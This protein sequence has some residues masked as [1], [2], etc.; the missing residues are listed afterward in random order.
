MVTSVN[1]LA[2]TTG[3]DP[4]PARKVTLGYRIEKDKFGIAK[5][6]QQKSTL[7]GPPRVQECPVQMEAELSGE[8]V[9]MDDVSGARRGAALAIEVTI[10][11]VHVLERLRMKGHQ[12][13]I[14]P[15]LWRPMIMSFQQ[16]YGLRDGKLDNSKLAEIDE[17][18]YRGPDA[19]PKSTA[20]VKAVAS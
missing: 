16:L 20:V 18:L 7:V 15:D 4:I 10:L 1:A 12:N 8:H 2:R 5:L 11:Q 17:E 19:K 9:M 14:D 13:R 3:S 6:T